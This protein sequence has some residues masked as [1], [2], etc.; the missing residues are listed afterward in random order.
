MIKIYVAMIFFIFVNAQ[1][2]PVYLQLNSRYPSGH[3]S[4]SFLER[5]TRA[6]QI[7][8]W[9]RV[10]RSDGKIGWAPEGELI[11]AL[12]LAVQVEVSEA[13]PIR[14][15][16]ELDSPWTQVIPTGS[17]GKIIT[18]IDSWT[19]VEFALPGAAGSIRETA[20]IPNETLMIR[21]SV[22]DSIVSL[23]EA[24]L[25]ALPAI[26]TRLNGIAKAWTTGRLKGHYG[27][28]SR[29]EI[30]GVNGYIPSELTAYPERMLALKMSLARASTPLRSAPVPY[31]DVIGHIQSGEKL[32]L[33]ESAVVQWGSAFINGMG[34]MWWP[35]SDENRGEV[36]PVSGEPKIHLSI[37]QVRARK[38]FD[39]VQSP[40][41]PLLRLVSADGIFLT[42]D[43]EQFLQIDQFKGR[44]FPL[45]VAPQG[46]IFV[47]PYISEDHGETFEQWIRWDRLVS[48]IPH[49][50][51][52]IR[53]LQLLSVKPQDAFGRTVE[54]EL[55]FGHSTGRLRLVTKDQGQTWRAL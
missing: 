17:R 28:F 52:Q 53:Q 11:T 29:A 41:I 27:S 40:S 43:G 25:F 19:Q 30:S 31:A 49:S 9:M 15:N 45:A 37:E 4:K 47:G 35:I 1:A 44:N 46:T 6:L 12:D 10:K 13:V 20:W 39:Q 18:R 42:R 33:L 32:K 54:L 38:I 24:G 21:P 16:P 55:G 48:S 23:T 5:N 26:A 14:L 7:Q 2:M 51:K 22:E 36:D 34:W 3:Y 50:G 8:R